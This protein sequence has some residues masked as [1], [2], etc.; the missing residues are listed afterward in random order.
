MIRLAVVGATGL[1]GQ[2]VL[3]IIEERK[4]EFDSIRLLASRESAGKTIHFRGE[5][6][7]V[8]EAVPDSF[9]E[10][11]I[12]IFSAGTEISKQ[13]IPEAVKRG[14]AVIDNS[15]A[16]RMDEDVPLLVPEVNLHALAAHHGIIANP[17]CSTAQMVVVLK[18]LYDYTRIRRIWVSTYQSVSGTGIKA[19]KELTD[20]SLQKLQGGEAAPEVYQKPIAFNLIPQIDCFL[21]N[22]YTQEEMKLVRETRKILED[23]EILIEATAVRVPVFVGHSE[24][25]TIETEEPLTPELAR[26]LLRRAPGVTVADAV[27]EGLYPTPLDVAGTDDVAVGRIR[28][29][30]QGPNCLSLWIVGDNLRKGAALN[31]VQILE[32]LIAER[33]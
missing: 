13:L 11:D 16:F 31:A 14:T 28:Q 25:V 26:E 17:N 15:N 29:S 27:D 3:Q 10:V 20:Q 19:V 18:P 2:E 30:L 7:S 5:E 1:V 23:E 12:A 22:G 33:S 24:A 32:H 4:L 21:E 9:T 8:E 6:Y